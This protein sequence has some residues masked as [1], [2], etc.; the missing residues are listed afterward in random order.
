MELE[1]K[2]ELPLNLQAVVEGIRIMRESLENY[3][4]ALLKGY[5]PDKMETHIAKDIDEFFK[6]LR[7]IV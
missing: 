3:E 1:R 7:T 4:D 6:Q 2:H 5:H